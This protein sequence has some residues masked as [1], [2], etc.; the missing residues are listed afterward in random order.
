MLFL[1]LD[2]HL[3]PDLHSLPDLILLLETP[4]LHLIRP[5]HLRQ[6]QSLVCSN[7]G[8]YGIRGE[9]KPLPRLKLP[10]ILNLLRS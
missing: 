5:Q 6:L 4:L 9:A 1:Q 7:R 8:T 10:V 3:L 2:Q